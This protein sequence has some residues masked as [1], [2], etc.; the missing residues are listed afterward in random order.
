[1]PSQRRLRRSLRLPVPNQIIPIFL[2]DINPRYSVRF[3]NEEGYSNNEYYHGSDHEPH[4]RSY[5]CQNVDYG[6]GDG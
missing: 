1:M 5:D 2:A 6:D 3:H 4:Y